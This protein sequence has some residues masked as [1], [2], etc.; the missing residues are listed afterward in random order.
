[1][2]FFAGL[3]GTGSFGTS[4][5]PQDFREMILWNAPNGTA[6]L[7]A[8]SAR[9]AKKEPCND[10][11]IHWWEE[12]NGIARATVNGAIT[13]TTT[14]TITVDAASGMSSNGG[15][16]FAPGDLLMVEQDVAAY[17]PEFLKVVSVTNDTTIVV[18]RGAASSTAA[19]IGDGAG[20]LRV[21]SAHEEGSGSPTTV[22]RNPTKFTNYT[23]IFKTPYQ[24]TNTALETYFRTGDPLKN[25]QIRKSFVHSEKIE[26]ALFWGLAS[27]NTGSG[28]MPERT[29]AGLRS[30]ITT[31][32]YV[33]S[34][35]PTLTDLITR[36]S[37]VF[38][39]ESGGAGNERIIYAGNGAIN[40][41]NSLVASDSS[42][43]VNYDGKI[44]MY[45]Q[46]MTQFSIP[47]GTFAIKSHP[48]FNVHPLYT[49]S[50]FIVN[51]AGV[52]YRPLKNR[53]TKI[54]KNIQ[55]ND[56]DL[57]KDQWLTEATLE[58]NYESSFAYFGGIKD[59]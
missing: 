24:V 31:N 45:G 9:M 27:E 29:M 26:Q 20:L 3:R 17:D 22:S 46:V 38:D 15:L 19:A 7:F 47:Q 51:P 40:F 32:K 36:L 37:A 1:M 58:L 4:E 25:D 33:Y 12:T 10:P 56:D 13:D 30:L 44:N 53:D 59:W 34:S 2:A 42:V 35:D 16:Q 54:Q 23:Q 41:W 49:Y 18:T 6:P 48:L 21:G 50:M 28:G 5:R 39:Y 8:L 11:Q 57:R 55:D 43:R 52:R 14:A